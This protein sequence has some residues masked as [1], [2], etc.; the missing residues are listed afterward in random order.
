MEKN[1][2][3]RSYHFVY[4]K[5]DIT[6]VT[7]GPAVFVES[8]LSD[9]IDYIKYSYIFL[10]NQDERDFIDCLAAEGELSISDVDPSVADPLLA[11]TYIVKDE[12]AGVYRINGELFRKAIDYYG[13]KWQTAYLNLKK[14]GA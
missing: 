4:T 13:P 1:S 14:N 11:T 10:M 2:P 7:K 8:Y 3:H 12:E 6:Q 5:E 9:V